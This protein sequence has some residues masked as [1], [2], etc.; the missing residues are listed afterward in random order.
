MS[1]LYR[2]L[3]FFIPLYITFNVSYLDLL[4]ITSR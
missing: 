1:T 2:A 3:R 4:Q